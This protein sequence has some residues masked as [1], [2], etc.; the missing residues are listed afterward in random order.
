[1]P[2]HREMSEHMENGR[3]WHC[4][5]PRHQGQAMQMTLIAGKPNVHSSRLIRSTMFK[6]E[7]ISDY[8]FNCETEFFT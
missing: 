8:F 7:R 2:G 5:G 1:M 6:K 4:L 3:G